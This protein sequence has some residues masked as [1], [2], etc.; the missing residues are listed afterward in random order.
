MEF[1]F[2]INLRPRDEW[3]LNLK[4]Y[5]VTLKKTKNFGRLKERGLGLE[6]NL[7]PLCMV[8]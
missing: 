7:F 3:I 4:K 5:V 8:S 2:N 6:Q 1:E